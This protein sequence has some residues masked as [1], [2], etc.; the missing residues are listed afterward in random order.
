MER[1]GMCYLILIFVLVICIILLCI[2]T[3][4]ILLVL[5]MA[6]L[7]AIFLYE[8]IFLMCSEWKAEINKG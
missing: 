2:F 3:D 5:L 4:A 8:T 6:M 1:G 7:V